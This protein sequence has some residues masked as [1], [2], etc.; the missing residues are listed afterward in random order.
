MSYEAEVAAILA[1]DPT[2]NAILTGGIFATATIGRS[3][4]TRKNTPSA[5]DA[6]GYLKPC[7]LVKERDIVPIGDVLDFDAQL[8]SARQAVEVWLYE[9]SGYANI[10]AAVARVRALLMGEMLANSFELRLAL[11]V[12]RRRDEG[13][14][15]GA[16]MERLDFQVDFV[17]T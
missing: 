15:A 11:H 3:G 5:F 8:E 12:R 2:L 10:D 14:L 6:D 13:A 7:A 1:A 16:S 9:N 4:I 17:L